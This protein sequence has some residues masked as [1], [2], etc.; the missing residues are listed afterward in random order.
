MQ[1]DFDG[2]NK[3][4]KSMDQ[5]HEGPTF[6]EREV[7]WCS[8]GVNIG[9]EQN[10]KGQKYNRPVLIIKKFNHRLFWGIPLTTQIK[11]NQHYHKFHFFNKEQC[12]MLTQLRLWDSTRLTHKLE[13]LAE[14]EF[15]AIKSKLI[16]YL[17]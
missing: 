10:G 12:A 11:D 7:W 4:K 14:K 17:E 13:R 1:K 5:H 8:I 3:T 16:Y 6:K 2:W 15:K 9:H